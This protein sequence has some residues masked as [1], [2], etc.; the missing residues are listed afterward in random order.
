[1]KLRDLSLCLLSMALAACIRDRASEVELSSPESADAM[2]QA[3]ANMGNPLLANKG[4]INAVNVSVHSSEELES[5]DNGSQEE[6][7]W[8]N[9]DDP[10][11]EIPGLTQA[12]ENKRLGYGWQADMGRAIQLARREEKPLLI[13]FH[14]SQTSPKSNALG[15]EYLTTKEFDDWSHDRIVRLRLDSGASQGDDALGKA[16]YSSQAINALQR[17]YGLKKKPSFAVITPSGKIAA[18]IDGFD[19][20]LSGF[21]QELRAGVE[22]AQREYKQYKQGMRER[23][24]REW[25]ARRG[26]K[27]VF[28]KLMRYDADKQIVYLKE[29]GGRVTST[30][31]ASFS[32]DDVEYLLSL[33]STGKNGPRHPS[34]E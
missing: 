18:R 3:A 24:Y 14:D 21:V 23:G 7:I 27:V 25:H 11:A 8:T 15:S 12:F 17:R 28:A 32:T 22:Q 20:F 26:D 31:L 10:N 29:P 4:D 5:I 6:L 1:M 16:R 34:D 9:P 2:E 13:W 33:P 30:K 19:G